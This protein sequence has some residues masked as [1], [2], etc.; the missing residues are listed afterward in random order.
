M[1]DAI[2]GQDL[3]RNLNLGLTNQDLEAIQDHDHIKVKDKKS[4]RDLRVL[5]KR[6]IIVTVNDI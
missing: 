2:R 4:V 5:K 6:H 3:S 1:V